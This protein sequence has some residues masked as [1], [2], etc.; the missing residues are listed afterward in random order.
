MCNTNI[1]GRRNGLKSGQ[2]KHFW[3]VSITIEHIFG[4]SN[5]TNIVI[6]V[7]PFNKVLQTL[8]I[9]QNMVQKYNISI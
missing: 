8:V 4:S 1:Q 2:A 9:M 7:Y 6:F 3:C 5:S